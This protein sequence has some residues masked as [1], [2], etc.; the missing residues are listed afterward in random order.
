MKIAIL[1]NDISKGYY[2][3]SKKIPIEM[4]ES[5]KTAYV[6]EWRTYQELNTNLEKHRGQAYSLIL[7]QFT[8]LLQSNMEQDMAW[9][10]TSTYYNPLFLLQLIKKTVLLQTEDQYT[11]A[12]VYGRELTLYMFHQV[13]INNP[14]LYEHFSTKVG[15][16][17]TI[18]V[19]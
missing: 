19:T 3:L 5:E 16:S 14:Q 17:E 18:G 11:F 13:P 8:Q 6:N 9:N 10:A 2:D 4:L 15:V 7:V 12:T 1:D